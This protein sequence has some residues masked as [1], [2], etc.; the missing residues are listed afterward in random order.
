MG[1]RPFAACYSPD[2]KSPCWDANVA[3]GQTKIIYAFG[4]YQAPVRLLRPSR[5]VLYHVN[6][7]L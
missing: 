6:G 5:A 1:N 3:L 2:T 4:W 7:K